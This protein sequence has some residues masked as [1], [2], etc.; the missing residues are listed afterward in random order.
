MIISKD[1][2]PGPIPEVVLV[3]LG[4]RIP[5]YVY[6]NLRD[7]K[8][9]FPFLELTLIHDSQVGLSIAKSLEINSFTS[10]NWLENERVLAESLEHPIDFRKGFWF[11]TLARFLSLAEFQQ[12][13]NV[14]IIQIECDVWLDSDFPF[15]KFRK[16]DRDIAFPMENETQGAASILWLRDSAASNMLK[17]Y[18]MKLLKQDKRHTDMTILGRLIKDHPEKVTTLPV[19]NMPDGTM[20]RNGYTSRDIYSQNFELFGGVFDALPY[21]MFLLG[22]DPGNDKGW[23]HQFRFLK[24][25]HVISSDLTFIYEEGTNLMIKAN[26]GVHKVFNLHN[27]S[28]NL[29]LW[30]WE[31]KTFLE[32]MIALQ[33]YRKSAVKKFYF[34]VFIKLATKALLRKIVPKLP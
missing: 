9:R 1:L 2:V 14:P 34:F 5:K 26:G 32:H 30:K 8:K 13:N 19:V 11:Q 25:H 17:D 29:K 22:S 15:D 21:G 24:E 27:H 20:F 12:S 6:W 16:L 10:T 3:Y 28:K 31:G 18:A 4:K 7:L 23:S 33:R